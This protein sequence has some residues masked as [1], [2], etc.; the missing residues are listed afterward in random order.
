MKGV[1]SQGL[2][3]PLSLFKDTELSDNRDMQPNIHYGVFEG[4]E[5]TNGLNVTKYDNELNDNKNSV[6]GQPKGKF[7]AFLRKTD[8]E[9][10]QNLTSYFDIH[11]DTEFEETLKLDGSSCTMYRWKDNLPKWKELLNK[12][13][14]MF[15]S[16]KFGVCSRNLELK[17]PKP[18]DKPSNFWEAAYGCNIHNDLPY[19]FAVQGEVLATNIQSNYEKVD[20]VKYYIFNVWD[21]T[22]QQYLPPAEARKFVHNN[23][24]NSHYVPIK[25]EAVKLFSECTELK[26][27]QDR[28]SGP[29]IH[30]DVYSE[31]RVYKSLD[32]HITF[33]CISNEYLL[34]K[35]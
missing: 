35:K 5:V 7:P 34:K 27:L 22:N 21:I 31:G 26:Q 32:G 4:L 17:T 2:A 29:S 23:L 13:Y 3:L 33:K 24:P 25:S 14:P 10:I 15:K 20:E 28:V 30:K 12:L 8:Q 18:G 6:T 9:R 19:G 11:K 16:E 1:I